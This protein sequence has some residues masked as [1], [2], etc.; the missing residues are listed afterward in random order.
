MDLKEAFN[1]RTEKIRFEKYNID[2][3]KHISNFLRNYVIIGESFR[4]DGTETYLT[5]IGSIEKL[6]LQGDYILYE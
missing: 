2:N 5:K 1:D 3:E 4:A 6:Y